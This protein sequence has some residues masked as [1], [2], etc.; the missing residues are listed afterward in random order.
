MNIVPSIERKRDG[1]TLSTKEILEFVKGA[2]DQTTPE[3]QLGAMLMAIFKSGMTLEETA[4]L[5]TAMR[6]SGTKLHFTQG[7]PVVDKH[8]TG[9]IGDKVSLPLAPLLVACGCRVP[10]ISGRGLGITGGTLDKLE[11][12]PGFRTTLTEAEIY[13]QIEEVGCVICGQTDLMV[14]ADRTLYAL[15]NASGTVPSLPLLVSS[16]LSKKL[17]EGLEYLVLDVKYGKGAFMSDLTKAQ[18]LASAMV[19]LGNKCGV[20][21]TAILSN[22]NVPI[23]RAIGNWWEIK[24]TADYLEDFSKFPDLH[25]LVI[26]CAQQILGN[27]HGL[28][29]E[30]VRQLCETRLKSKAVSLI[31]AHMLEAQGA[32]MVLYQITLAAGKANHCVNVTSPQDGFITDCDARILGETVKSIGGGRNIPTDTIDPMAGIN[33]LLK[34]GD[35]VVKG[36]TLATIHGANLDQ[37]NSVYQQV[38]NAFSFGTTPPEKLPLVV[39]AL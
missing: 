18:E 23:G 37:L 7:K 39:G 16:I 24:E 1:A 31:W 29:P 27:T 14:P 20:K 22:M 26:A 21:T 28:K 3:V 34:P 8:S 6:D 36:Q 4:S 25:E 13:K 33:H 38:L 15:R 9:G 5:T 32:D 19:N 17:A 11:A 12:I 10:M 35:T 2:A 30:T